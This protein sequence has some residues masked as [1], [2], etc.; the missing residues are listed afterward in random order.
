MTHSKLYCIK[1]GEITALLLCVVA[2]SA[3]ET[4]LINLMS[5]GGKTTEGEPLAEDAYYSL[6]LSD[7]D[8]PFY[9]LYALQSECIS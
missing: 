2:S 3:K 7:S 6:S 5:I 8:R 1:K 9:D 4:G